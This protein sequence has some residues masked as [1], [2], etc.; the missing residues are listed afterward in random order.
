MKLATQWEE[1]AR[2]RVT[3]AQ[4][5]RVLSDIHEQ[6]HGT[7]LST[8]SL[9]AF[10]A[11]WLGRKEGE[12]AEVTLRAYRHAS[13]EFSTFLGDRAE[14]P[15]HYI[16]P[17]QVAAWRDAAAAKASPRTANNKLKIIRTLFQSAWRDGLLT[18]NPAAKVSA[19]KAGRSRRR[20]F[21]IGELRAI[22]GVASTEWRGMVLAGLYTGQRLKD[23]ASLT[24]ANV[25][26][27]RREI[28]LSTSKTGRQQIIPIAKPFL[29]YLEALPAGDDPAAPLFPAAYSY[30]IR[31][32]GSSPLSQQFHELMVASG[33]AA[34]R[35]PKHVAAGS[36][37]T[38]PRDR[39]TVSFH[40]LRHTATSLFKAAG[41]SE[42]VTR[43][44]I[45]HESAEISRHY[46]HVDDE[47]KRAAMEKLPDL[48]K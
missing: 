1:S 26:L 38:A 29:V 8:P 15:I 46:T 27:E 44:I 21:T 30:G 18:D 33:L 34:P 42:S 16:T 19:L 9:Q 13:E 14:Q 39:S 12:T 31:A 11:Q 4:A 23:I 28:R 43:D 45:G 40:S 7:K 24:W 3:E 47:A 25:D 5:R 17:A 48:T 6:I 37:R 41:V 36:G 32:G 10:T 2:G 35:A 22:L 20:A